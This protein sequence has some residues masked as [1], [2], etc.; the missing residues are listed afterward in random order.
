MCPNKNESPL[1]NKVVN[2]LKPFN[3]SYYFVMVCTNY[4]V[5][6]VSNK[7]K[8]YKVQLQFF[9]Q[10]ILIY[11]RQQCPLRKYNTNAYKHSKCGF[12]VMT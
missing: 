2:I 4:W 12:P 7:S 3:R 10:F 5:V 8:E 1:Y 9:L 11:I 6:I